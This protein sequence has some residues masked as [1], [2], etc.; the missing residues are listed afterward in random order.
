MRVKKVLLKGKAQYSW[1]PCSNRFRSAPFYIEDIINLL[2]KTSFL[3]KEVNCTESPPLVSIPCASF[4]VNIRWP[5]SEIDLTIWWKA[6]MASQPVV[7]FVGR[8][9][10]PHVRSAESEKVYSNAAG[11]V[12]RATETASRCWTRRRCTG[13]QKENICLSQETSSYV[14]VRFRRH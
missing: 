12:G 4:Q 6:E 8:R 3:N 1:P 9:R 11:D 14:L 5:R 10:R 7:D 2:Y 13:R